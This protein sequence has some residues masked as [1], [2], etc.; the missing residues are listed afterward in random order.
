LAP[1]PL[2]ELLIRETAVSRRD[3]AAAVLVSGAANTAIL[4]IINAASA[5]A[6][7][8][9]LDLRLLLMF[10]VA[11]ALYVLGLGYTFDAATR[12][13][14]QAL[15]RVRVRLMER[16][17]GSELLLLQKVG[18]PRIFQTI[19]QDTSLISESQGLL[20]AAGHSVVMVAC[21]GIYVLTVSLP[22]FLG[23]AA[24]VTAGILLYLGRSRHMAR[25]L[26]DSS[27][28]EVRFVGI[29]GDLVDGLKEIKLS[30]ARR[31]ALLD[32]VADAAVRLRT[33]KVQAT[34]LYNRNAVFSQCFF[35][36]LIAIIVFVLP[37]L[38]DGFGL[39][40]PE[41]VATVLFVIGPLST[42]VTAVPAFTKANA[43]AASLMALEREIGNEADQEPP[44]PLAPTPLSF[45]HEIACRGIEFRYPGG[46]EEGAFHI[47][48]IDLAIRH[49]EI[50]I[51]IG[52]NGSGKTT[53]L[54][55]LAG[56]Y[57][58]TAG[59]LGLDG[60]PVAPGR[61]PEYRGMFGAIFSDF[62]LFRKLYGV[63]AAADA[64]AAQFSQ[65]HIADKVAYSKDGFSTTQLSTGQRKRVAMAVALLEDRPVLIFDEWAAEQDPEFR[66]Y[67]YHKLLP[68]LRQA[69]KTLL[70]A[71][72]DDRFFDVADAIVKLE[73]G[74]VQSIHRK[75]QP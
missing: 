15:A 11:M 18:K 58:P 63:P 7:H 27:A 35:Y 57:M 41:L 66:E 64:I 67:F 42:I 19:T 60:Q 61:M 48:P 40:V 5:A 38:L 59:S 20:V 44:D 3:V 73:L 13:I 74:R 8:G 9:R 37:R 29:A 36:L 25:L 33:L 65:L 26:A 69:G 32:E 1:I 4:A 24:V 17:A 54:K 51:F 68:D 39:A 34:T 71:T 2:T 28:E 52:G 50:T 47:G 46:S 72:H 55:V 31:D 70:V 49:G 10:G 22:A 14:E 30:H 16:I 6:A 75:G 45:A 56:L 53:L 62:H 23:I 12:A 43:A 21:T